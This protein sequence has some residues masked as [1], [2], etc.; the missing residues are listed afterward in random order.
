VV[1]EI[2]I[3]VIVLVAVVVIVVVVVVV[4]F[5]RNAAKH[6]SPVDRT[7][8]TKLTTVT[9]IIGFYLPCLKQCHVKV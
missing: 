7:N 3:L 9:Y 1:V 6:S 5:A 4:A 8:I 2:E